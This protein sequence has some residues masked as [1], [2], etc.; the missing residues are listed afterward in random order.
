MGLPIDIDTVK[1]KRGVS[2]SMCCHCGKPGHW[3]CSYLEGLNV[4]YLS[5]NK[6]DMLIIELLATM[7]ASGIPSPEV[8]DRTLEDRDKNVLEDF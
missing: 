3:A 4:C 2:L 8:T 6:Q 7:N 1:R 5:A